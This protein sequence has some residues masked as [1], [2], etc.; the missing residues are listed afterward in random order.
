MRYS[1]TLLALAL[2]ACTSSVVSEDVLID[3]GNFRPEGICMVSGNEIGLDEGSTYALVGQQVYG[4]ID[5]WNIET[6]E[7]TN[8]VP[9]VNYAER[10]MFGVWYKDGYILVAGGGPAVPALDSVTPALHVF[11]AGSG[12]LLASCFPT[13]G[14]Y[15]INDVATIDGYA[16]VTDS[17]TNKL[18]V[19][20]LEPVTR[21]ECVVSSIELPEAIFASQEG[22]AAN[23]KWK[24][25][26]GVTLPQ[27]FFHA[28]IGSL[29]MSVLSI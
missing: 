15:F 25:Q 21:G 17:I 20:E 5:A 11:E 4:G 10:G 22:F 23:G 2:L 18:M 12:S 24:K 29:T 6:G 7:K 1:L 19:L 28:M 13:G 16:Y 14:G 26:T 9:S 3:I 8:V 27:L